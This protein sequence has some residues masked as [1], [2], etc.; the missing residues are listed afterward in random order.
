M[1]KLHLS[2]DIAASC[3]AVWQ[4][5]I[6]DTSYRQ[7]TRPF[8]EGSYFV[9]RWAAGES[10]RFLSPSGGG[11][12]SVIAELRPQAFISIKHLGYIHNEVED[13]DS[14]A[15]RAWAPAFENYTFIATA[16]GTTLHIEQDMSDEYEHYMRDAWPKAL[17]VLKTLCEG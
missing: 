10:I 1:K 9:G 12:V 16:S 14:E 17:A 4:A 7:W 6:E 3:E 13:T 2:V 8:C 11:M 15:V 5:V